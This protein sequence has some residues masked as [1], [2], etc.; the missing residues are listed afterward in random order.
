[1]PE[2]FCYA[3]FTLHSSTLFS[4]DSEGLD[5]LTRLQRLPFFQPTFELRSQPSSMDAVATEEEPSALTGNPCWDLVQR[6]VASPPFTKS[7]R[8]SSFL[9]FVCRLSLEG[10]NR[11]ITGQ[12]IGIAV[13]GRKADYD[14]SVDGIV[15]SHATRLRQRLE[16]YFAEYGQNETLMVE[17]PP[18]SYVPVFT[19]R[20]SSELAAA[21][22]VDHAVIAVDQVST[23]PAMEAASEP[24]SG[25][26][27]WQAKTVRVLAMVFIVTSI[28][29]G[30]S[31][32]YLAIHPRL[33]TEIRSEW[34]GSHH[35]LWAQMFNRNVDTL[36][37]SGD[38]GLLNF[39]IQTD[40]SVLLP[41]YTRN[42][43]IVHYLDG[44]DLSPSLPSSGVFLTKTMTV[45]D[46]QFIVGLYKLPGIKLDRTTFKPAR[47]IQLPN[48][49]DE[50][51]VLL[52]DFRF[53]PWVQAFEPKMNFYFSDSHTELTNAV[54][55]NRSPRNN[56]QTSYSSTDINHLH[57]EYSVIAYQ[58]NLSGSG[59]ALL[60][61][62]QSPMSTEA[63]ADF[64]E[65]DT[66]LM[67]FLNKIREKDGSI[68]HFEVLLKVKGMSGNAASSEMLSYR[69]DKVDK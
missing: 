54:L 11:K 25:H 65:N 47:D 37:V 19:P 64:V 35:P 20:E 13:F 14:I 22:Q 53:D 51:I 12:N 36:V 27:I 62:G 2:A 39:E 58:P 5:G 34:K 23:E 10:Q 68:P 60:L 26:A 49:K 46:S 66:A 15:R 31:I 67:P 29:T 52:G 44:S 3:R 7:E 43:Y 17:I 28:W 21:P 38:V 57:T 55:M 16:L 61:E 48:L 33:L 50:N 4:V 24:S 41:E 40:R 18:G 45:V 8:L 6:I 9:L 63:A 30:L 42:D 32:I 59:N 1:M 69:V 56:E